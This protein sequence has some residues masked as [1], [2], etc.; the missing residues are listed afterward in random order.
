MSNITRLV[1]LGAVR[2]FEP[3]HGYFLR[4][5]LMTWHVDEWANIQPGSIYNALKS[6]KQDGYIQENGTEAAGKRPERT[7]YQTTPNGVVELMR[8]LRQTLWTVETFDTKPVM[9][10]TSFMFLL[11]R[12]EVVAALKVRIAEIDAKVASNGFDIG[13]VAKSTTTPAYVRE[14]FEL[15][16]LRLRA[17]QEWARGLY[18]RIL[19]GAYTFAD[20]VPAKP[21]GDR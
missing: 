16:S 6:L 12:A 17:E 2:Q 1:V 5:E 18:D 11:S 13:D 8:L 10:L 4:R 7:I 14:I 3:V 19:A 15:S 20:E 21:A 9:A